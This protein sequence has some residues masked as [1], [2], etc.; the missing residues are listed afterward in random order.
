[1]PEYFKN[2]PDILQPATTT[3]DDG[4]R[5]SMAGQKRS[6]DDGTTSPAQR[7]QTARNLSTTPPRR[8]PAV[9]LS[10]TPRRF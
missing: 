3:P 5:A 1:M 4:K 8:F 9:G 10:K 2:V 7:T 6:A